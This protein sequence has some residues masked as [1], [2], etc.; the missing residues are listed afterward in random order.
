M[1]S[2]SISSDK[3][4]RGEYRFRILGVSSGLNCTLLM[5]DDL[6]RRVTDLQ[7][8]FTALIHH[9]YWFSRGGP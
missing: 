8:A 9:K 4:V 7:V 5:Q 2:T 1:G 6:L 3:V